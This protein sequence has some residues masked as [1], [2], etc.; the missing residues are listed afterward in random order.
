VSIVSE[1]AEAKEQKQRDRTSSRISIFDIV[2]SWQKEANVEAKEDVRLKDEEAADPEEEAH[3][4][5]TT[6]V[7]LDMLSRR[8]LKWSRERGCRIAFRL[9]SR[10]WNACGL[11]S[12]NDR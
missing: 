4:E 12:R 11:K 9:A 7:E 5:P 10:H 1:S 8:C 2:A 6:E 3:L